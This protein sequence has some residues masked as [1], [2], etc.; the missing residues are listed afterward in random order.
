MVR[1]SDMVFKRRERREHASESDGDPAS[2]KLEI[3]IVGAG[4]RNWI[5]MICM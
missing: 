3:V 2:M 1:F 4:G 5:L